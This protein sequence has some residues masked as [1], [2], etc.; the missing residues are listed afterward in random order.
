MHYFVDIFLT[1]QLCNWQNCRTS[2][3]LVKTDGMNDIAG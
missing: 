2:P 1:E 3:A